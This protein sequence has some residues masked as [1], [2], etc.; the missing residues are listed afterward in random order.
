MSP[1]ICHW[2]TVALPSPFTCP[3]HSSTAHPAP[4]RGAPALGLEVHAQLHLKYGTSEFPSLTQIGF[5]FL[6]T[7]K[8]RGEVQIN[9]TIE[10][11]V[12]RQ[13]GSPE[14]ISQPFAG[15]API[16]SACRLGCEGGSLPGSAGKGADKWGTRISCRHVSWSSAPLPS[17]ERPCAAL[18][19]ATVPNS[20]GSPDSRTHAVFYHIMLPPTSC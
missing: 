7:P 9:N 6:T 3:L 8:R 4:C 10:S 17:A 16:S 1:T 15:K 18:S 14:E 13:K 5:P 11:T 2:A 19:W 20:H 12:W